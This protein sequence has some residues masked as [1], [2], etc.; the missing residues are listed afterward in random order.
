M[1]FPNKNTK[2]SKNNFRKGL[3]PFLLVAILFGSFPLK[4]DEAPELGDL[5]SL[6]QDEFEKVDNK[7]L[8]KR[9]QNRANSQKNSEKDLQTEENL[10]QK[11][12]NKETGRLDLSPIALTNQASKNKAHFEGDDVNYDP[13]SGSFTI[14][15]SAQLNILDQRVSLSADRIEYLPKESK[16]KAIGNVLINGKDQLTFS[17]SLEINL[18]NNDT[19][20]NGVKTQT[21]MAAII[22]KEGIVKSNK[23][24]RSA[25]YSQG[26]FKMASPIQI[27]GGMLGNFES[28]RMT[29][30][31]NDAPIEALAQNSQSFS[32]KANKLTYHPDRIQ[33]NLIIQGASLKFKNAPIKIPIPYYV[34]TAGESG[35]QMFGLTL[36]NNPRTGAGDFNVG[37][38]L[39]FVLGDP[40]K[41]R[42]IHVSPFVQTGSSLGF[43]GML[44]YSDLKNTALL[45]YGSAKGRGLAEVTSRLTKHN[46]FVYGWNSYSAG[47]ITKQFAQVND[48]RII[49]I[50]I[51]GNFLQNNSISSMADASFIN[52]SQELR[53]RENNLFS[54][55]QN[56]SL[57]GSNRQKDV[58]GFRF[59][60]SVAFSTK[61]IIDIGTEKYN[62]A[63]RL[64]SVSSARFY[65]TGDINLFTSLGPMIRVHG[66]KFTDFEFGYQQ[67]LP[68]GKSPFGFDQVIQGQ[69]SFVM[70]GDFNL[71]KWLSIGGGG[72]YSVT[73]NNWVSQQIRLTAG[74]EDFKL[75]LG[76]DPVRKQIN[77]S[78][79][80]LFNDKV[81]YKKFAYREDLTRKKKRRF[82][83][84]L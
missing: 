22:G 44:K 34:M 13:D 75:S 32:I 67:L 7:Q 66:H 10:G 50:P 18:N 58:L 29:Q 36:G 24:Y 21:P 48:N 23:N 28:Y 49:K 4:A 9:A 41:K 47:G 61:P 70:N 64:D 77:F 73:R 33:N 72:I 59:Q 30:N 76:F 3:T 63:L 14:Q 26:N 37:P 5:I 51:I 46:N 39:S 31:Y 81:D 16:L 1:L 79:N 40:K 2:D 74:P 78:F 12:I 25:D 20:L 15:G 83:S 55:L 57:G 84:F 56:D 38:K 11:R 42:A 69:Q 8:K 80:L 68:V 52:D 71:S 53:N 62:A 6:Q 54:R 82:S 60:E 27:R 65:T 19:Y 17:K 35:Q 43:G 45:G